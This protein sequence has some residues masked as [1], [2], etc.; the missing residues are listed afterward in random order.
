MKL[1]EKINQDLKNAMISKDIEKR[2]LLRVVIGEMNRVGK[3]VTDEN[4]IKIIRKMQE[5]AIQL[6]NK[7]EE[8]I[9]DI[10]LPKM[11]SNE[12]L[13]KIISNIMTINNFS[14]IKDTG[15]IMSELKVKYPSQYD[16]KIASD[17]VRTKLA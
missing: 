2:D 14:T 5:N 1:Q 8:E 12:D 7:I 4:V 6:N 13:E 11:L 17:I 9:L 16:G 15:K 10:Y 3:E